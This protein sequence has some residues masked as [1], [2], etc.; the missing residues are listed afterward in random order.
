MKQETCL[1]G[2]LKQKNLMLFLGF[3]EIDDL[4]LRRA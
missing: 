2:Q 3:N 4:A 1:T